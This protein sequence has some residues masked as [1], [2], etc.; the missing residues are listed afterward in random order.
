MDTTPEYFYK[1]IQT[2][3]TTLE[4]IPKPTESDYNTAYN[5]LATIRKN[6]QD[7]MDRILTDKPVRSQQMLKDYKDIYNTHYMTNFCLI[8]GM[9]LI[10]W[11]I[12]KIN[13]NALSTTT[14]TETSLLSMPAPILAGEVAR[15]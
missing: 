6:I 7:Q 12:V 4:A 10:L 14:P 2:V 8:L 9:G 15:R 5:N 3:Q 11:Y 13:S 1:E